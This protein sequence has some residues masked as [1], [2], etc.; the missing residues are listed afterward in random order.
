MTEGF[1][2]KSYRVYVSGFSG[3]S[4]PARSRQMALSGAWNAYCNYRCI[5][6]KEF[7]KI[8]RAVQEEPIKRFGEPITVGGRPAF[9]V[10]HNRQYIQF[11]RPWMDVIL[12]SHPFDV[13]PPSARRGTPYYQEQA[14]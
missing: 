14:A 1:I 12:S 10:G 11:V 9:Y 7:L 13:E 2:L 6:F 3:Y 5:C 4:Y 8:A